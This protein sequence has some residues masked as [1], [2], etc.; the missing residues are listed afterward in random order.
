M[1]IG[2]KDYVALLATQALTVEEVGTGIGDSTQES[3]GSS[4]RG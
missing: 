1:D 2:K 4:D 3:H